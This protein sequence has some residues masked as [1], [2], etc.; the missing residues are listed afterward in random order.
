MNFFQAFAPVKHG[1]IYVGQQ[2]N[3][4]DFMK[5]MKAKLTA[6]SV[7]N[8]ERNETPMVER[9]APNSPNIDNPRV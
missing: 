6:V 4:H 1:N 7:A 5:K 8:K 2:N 3:G 9:E